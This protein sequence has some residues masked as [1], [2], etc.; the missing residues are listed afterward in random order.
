MR[1]P[2]EARPWGA[3]LAELALS[4]GSAQV[5]VRAETGAVHAIAFARG[6]IVGATSPVAAD[7][8][9]RVAVTSRIATRAQVEAFAKSRR[10]TGDDLDALIAALRLGGVLAQELR[11]RVLL[12]R[13]ARTFAIERGEYVIEQRI[14]IPVMTGA[15][16]D[17][18][19]VVYHGAR[20]LLHGD[21]L[22]RELRELGSRFV[23][24]ATTPEVARY[25]FGDDERAVLELLREGASI[26]ELEARRR[27]LDPRMVQA[28]VYALATCKA[29]APAKAPPPSTEE[30]ACVPMLIRVDP[31][32]ERPVAIEP[33]TSEP[34]ALPPP[35]LAP[36]PPVVAAHTI[37]RDRLARSRR[38]LAR[39]TRKWT[40]PFIEARPTTMRPNALSAHE[41]RALIAAGSEM[42]EQGADHFTSLGVPIGASVEDVRAAY[43]ELAR[44]LKPERLAELHIRDQEFHA[45]ALLAQITIAY[46][47]LTDPA[48]R[49]EYITELRRS[50]GAAAIDFV[51]L[52]TEAY[53]RGERAL[54]ADE[55]DIAV[56]ELRTACELAPDN[57]DYLALLA[58]AEFS[59]RA[60]KRD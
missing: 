36:R 41:L 37:P 59:A 5:T 10:G 12:Q 51:R 54:R 29:M 2:V 26:A 25:G 28:V 44:N 55:P 31:V 27:D 43:V 8:A 6:A 11:Q 53:E 39:G 9:A 24:T 60:V 17:V 50:R 1:G 15:D 38:E 48:R 14:S 19:A 45:R 47:V 13:A 3:V 49:A 46:T 16:V 52:A 22:A 18:R 30:V 40:E 21:R 32:V 57:I 33:P 20:M 23:L 7:T 56:A 58:R 4:R 42:L 34:P 35:P